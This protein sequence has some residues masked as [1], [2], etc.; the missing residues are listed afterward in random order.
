MAT[1]TDADGVVMRL[2]WMAGLL[3]WRDIASCLAEFG[4]ERWGIVI[5]RNGGSRV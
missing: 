4:G 1:L 3:V 2:V 5:R